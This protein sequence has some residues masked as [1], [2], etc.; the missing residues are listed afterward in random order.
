[1]TSREHDA[2]E[3]AVAERVRFGLELMDPVF[4]LILS[5]FRTEDLV[6]D[7]KGDDSPVTVADRGAE[8]LLRKRIESRFPDDGILGEE[9]GEKL[10]REFRWILDPI[11]GTESFVRGVPLFGT[12]VGIEWT[13]R[14]VGGI[15]AL[16]ALGEV[17]YAYSGHGAWVGRRKEAL[18]PARVSDVSKWKDAMLC[19]TSASLFQDPTTFPTLVERSGKTRGWGDCYA[20][21]LVATGR[22]EVAIDPLMNIWDSAPLLP[23]IQE[24]GG[25]FTDWKGEATIAGGSAVATNGRFHQE[26]LGVLQGE[27]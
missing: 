15:L 26:V 16:P 12:L 21:A 24:A 22:A 8:E 18:Q 17:I 20:Y 4:E 25:Q 3:Q 23:I 7:R 13:G 11:D 6:I 19:T 5:H 10:G 9:Y 14:A 1:M 2:I 27:R